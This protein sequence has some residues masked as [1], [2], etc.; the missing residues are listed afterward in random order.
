[1]ARRLDPPHERVHLT[2]AEH[3]ALAQLERDFHCEARAAPA[4]TERFGSV[5]AAVRHRSMV[6]RFWWAWLSTLLGAA[7]IALAAMG[8]APLAVAAIV[9]GVGALASVVAAG[10][11][12][13]RRRGGR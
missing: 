9:A 3:R 7:G 8:V 12:R 4:V 11:R 6:A 5:E 10:R 13:S 1:M 2:P